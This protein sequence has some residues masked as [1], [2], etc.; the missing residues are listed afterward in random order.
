MG[1]GTDTGQWGRRMQTG[2]QSRLRNEGVLR[3]VGLWGKGAKDRMSNKRLRGCTPVPL[4][5]HSF[6]GLPLLEL[7]IQIK[8]TL[9]MDACPRAHPWR[10]LYSFLAT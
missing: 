5:V 4:Q 3:E 9:E 2:R 7:H 6:S 1:V 10:H 8:E